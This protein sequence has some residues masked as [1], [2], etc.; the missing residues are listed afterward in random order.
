MTQAV[1]L[2]LLW[3]G[4]A[5]VF[6]ILEAATVQLVAIWL[7]VGA[8][9]TAIPAYFGVPFWGQFAIFAVVSAL[10]LLATRP[11]VKSFLRTKRERTNLD[12]VVGQEG[13]VLSAIPEGGFETGRVHALGLDWSAVSGDAQ[14]L[15]AGARVRIERI[16]GVKLVVSPV[17]QPQS[18]RQAPPENP[19]GE[20]DAQ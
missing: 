1:W 8:L 10:A 14:A 17:Q 13:V 3:I 18:P 19:G 20:M 4:V 7:A 12:R 6:F 16:D 11:L 15:P 2:T 9:V 5:V